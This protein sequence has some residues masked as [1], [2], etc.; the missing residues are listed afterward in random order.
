MSDYVVWQ[1]RE[2]DEALAWIR[3]FPP[4]IES[5]DWKLCK[6][7]SC[8]DWFPENPEV[9][10]CLEKG[11]KLSDAIPNHSNL[12]VANEKLKS[13]L[14]EHSGANI[15][16]FPVTVLDKKGRPDARSYY[17]ANLLDTVDCVD[18][19]KSEYRMDALI[20]TQVDR[21]AEIVFDEQRIDAEKQMFRLKD[22]TDLIVLT[23]GLA[24]KIL[25]AKCEGMRFVY[26]K[27]YGK[28]WRGK[29]GAD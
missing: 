22:K 26:L 13:L 25:D 3:D 27:D 18:M 29:L 7:I 20:K 5:E 23:T 9:R 14:D 19:E 21:F 8:S 10:V 12:L 2:S 11:V 4:N 28:F 16:Y 6:G 15:E 17:V 1:R 24:R